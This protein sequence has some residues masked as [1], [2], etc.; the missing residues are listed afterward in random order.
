[1]SSLGLK[2][3]SQIEENKIVITD[4]L[5]TPAYPVVLPDTAKAEF[6]K[7]LAFPNIRNKNNK[8]VYYQEMYNR[9]YILNHQK[10]DDEMVKLLASNIWY[11]PQKTWK[12]YELIKT[13]V[14]NQ[15][16]MNK[17]TGNGEKIKMNQA[18]KTNLD[19]LKNI[20]NGG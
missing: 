4:S 18:I 11:D 19:E 10:A 2:R 14:E 6:L 16:K 1:M 17:L 20:I 12:T 9:A 7:Q 8:V 13:L 3:L 5:L 15:D